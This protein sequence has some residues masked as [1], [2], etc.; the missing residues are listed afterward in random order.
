MNRL[1]VLFAVLIFIGCS[2]T[3]SYDTTQQNTDEKALKPAQSNAPSDI[4]R[5]EKVVDALSDMD[6]Q[7][8][9]ALKSEISDEHL[10]ETVQRIITQFYDDKHKED[11]IF[12]LIEEEIA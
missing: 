1:V 2:T 10:Q 3:Q 9:E 7:L 4:Q 12:R 8:Q 6:S 11:E 5:R